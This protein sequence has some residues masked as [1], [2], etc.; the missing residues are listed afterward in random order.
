VGYFYICL[1]I[2]ATHAQLFEEL[3]STHRNLTE[4]NLPELNELNGSVSGFCR[5]WMLDAG[6]FFHALTAL[7]KLAPK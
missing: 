2:T 5:C 3:N 4:L 1:H 7:Q 6:A